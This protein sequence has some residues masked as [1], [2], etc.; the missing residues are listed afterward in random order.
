MKRNRHIALLTL[1]A[2][3]TSLPLCRAAENQTTP[4]L[5]TATPAPATPL[6]PNAEPQFG[7][8]I[9]VVLRSGRE[10]SDY[11]LDLDTGRVLTPAPEMTPERLLKLRPA[12]TP[13]GSQMAW[14]TYLYGLGVDIVNEENLRGLAC[15]DIAL[16]ALDD[17]A[18]WNS[19]S[20]TDC[21]R[22]ADRAHRHPDPLS[23]GTIS[24]ADGSKPP[25]TWIFRTR[26][27][28]RGIFQITE[29][30]RNPKEVKLRFK[31]VQDGLRPAKTPGNQSP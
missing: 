7:P 19:L 22:L 18:K 24:F 27:G 14:E 26:E 3:L 20:A 15:Y 28:R 8:V 9:E 31:L 21:A 10:G 12:L 23:R 1:S 29:I 25:Y 16:D 11:L 6:P 4:T 13:L 30:Q 2:L 17:E 5:P